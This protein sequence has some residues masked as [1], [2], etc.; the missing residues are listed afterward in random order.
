MKITSV[1]SYLP[2]QLLK[3]VV[4]APS[5]ADANIVINPGPVQHISLIGDNVVRTRQQQQAARFD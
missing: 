3:A 4:L 1:S 2:F 5:L